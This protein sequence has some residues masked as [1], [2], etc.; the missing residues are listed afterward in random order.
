VCA[1]VG[2]EASPI[3]R[4]PRDDPFAL[5]VG[6]PVARG[7][8]RE[9][10]RDEIRNKESKQKIKNREQKNQQRKKPAGWA[11]KG[12]DLPSIFGPA[13]ENGTPI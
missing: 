4:G 7:R 5:F 11:S 3:A 1:A 12:D 9:R 6:R 2:R 10:E 8:E 13:K